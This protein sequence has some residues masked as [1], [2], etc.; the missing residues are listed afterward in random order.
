M[1]LHKEIIGHSKPFECP[2]MPY[3]DPEQLALS[4]EPS[5]SL[6]TPDEIFERA[7]QDLLIALKEDRRIERKPS[8][9]K[10]H[11]LA[12]YVSMWGN[13]K[14]HGGL[15]IVGM[16]N[17]GS[18]K[19]GCD[20]I[21][22]D[23]L[24][25][26]E[27]VAHDL[28]QFAKSD[29]K[30]IS[31]LRTNGSYDRL[32]L[33]RVFYN[34]DRVVRTH[35]NEAFIRLGE[36]KHK[37]SEAEI[38]ELE[39]DK[40]QT[41][42]ER[43][44]VKELRFPKDFNSTLVQQFA[45]NVRKVRQLTEDHTDVQILEHRRLGETD[46]KGDFIP[47]VAC[48]LLFAKDPNRVFPGCKI[49]FLR[50]EGEYEMSGEGFN[51]SKDDWVEGPIPHLIPAAEKLIQSQLRSFS[52]LNSK[53][54]KF[55]TAE[56]YPKQAWYEAI[57]NASVHRSYSLRNMVIFVK[58]FNDKLVIESPGGFPPLVTPE[59]IYDSHHPRNPILM[60]AM[61]FFE[62]VKAANE[63]TRRMRD[64]MREMQLPNPEFEE[65]QKDLSN[66]VRVTLRNNVKQRRMWVVSDASALL[67]EAISKE[68]TEDERIAVNWIA[69]HGRIKVSELQRLTSKTWPAASKLLQSMRERDILQFHHRADIDRDPQAYYTLR[70]LGKKQK[71]NGN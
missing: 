56:E 60:E 62:Y 35:K 29:T 19:R 26:F 1:L 37:L 58:M 63:G 12:E 53:D 9:I 46:E 30:L 21:S 70:T 27:N 2:I 11:L 45:N 59:N 44:P 36:S 67:G 51:A 14:P 20:S 69:E 31:S 25:E 24:N 68:L 33:I 49:R 34:R 41:S 64:K 7:N 32:L 28:C 18:V 50:F 71:S 61:Y 6:L 23:K 10:P 48:T 39:I 16:E 55:Y 42:F 4:F 47:N 13:T 38:R 65:K 66:Q 57:V 40:G 52:R 15:I 3:D 17:D 8:G 43:D 54:G 5:P 22:Q